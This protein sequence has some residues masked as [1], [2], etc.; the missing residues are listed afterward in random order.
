MKELIAARLGL[1]IVLIL[2]IQ[3]G[4]M[5]IIAADQAVCTSGNTFLRDG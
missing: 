1:N 5:M 3:T 4:I 2:H